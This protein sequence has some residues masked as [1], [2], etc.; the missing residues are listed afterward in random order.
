MNSEVIIYLFQAA[1][2][3]IGSVLNFISTFLIASIYSLICEWKL[4]LVLLSFS[5]L[6][7][8]SIYYEQNILKDDAKK[9]RKMLEKSAKVVTV[10]KYSFLLLS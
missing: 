1:G 4:S 7:L 2:V 8:F 6:I 3:Q 5:P 10:P 9:N